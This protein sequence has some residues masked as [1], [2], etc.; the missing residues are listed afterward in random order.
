PK[1]LSLANP[2]VMDSTGA[3]KLEDLPERLLVV[4]G[5]YIGLEMGS[6]YA[7]L[8]S[9]VTVVEFTDGLLPG[10]DRDLVLPLHKRLEGLFHKIYLS[11]KVAKLEDKGGTIKAT[12]EGEDVS[13][14]EQVFE[15]VLVSVGRR[16]NSAD[17]GLEKVG[18]E[19]D[20]QG[21]IKIDKKM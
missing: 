15:R 13:E 12:L 4:G 1:A 2:R 10:V 17:L 7:S 8:G 9:K 21:F 18:V 20:A 5:G 19:I 6:V 16:P 11:T 14:K 3:L